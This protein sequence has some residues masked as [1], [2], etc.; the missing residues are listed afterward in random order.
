MYYSISFF[1]FLYLYGIMLLI[2]TLSQGINV[3]IDRIEKLYI[4]RKK[5]TTV[6]VNSF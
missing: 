2:M 3:C 5:I 4:R 1:K 6:T